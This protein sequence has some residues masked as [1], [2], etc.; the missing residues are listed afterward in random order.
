VGTQYTT[1]PIPAFRP[2]S[3]SVTFNYNYGSV[4]P[5]S[6][7][8]A[9]FSAPL[10]LPDGAVLEEVRLLVSDTEPGQDILAQVVMFGQAVAGTLTCSST[11]WYNTSS[12]IFGRDILTLTGAPIVIQSRIDKSSCSNTDI[13]SQYY[14]EVLMGTPNESL[15]GAV[16]VWHRQVSPPPVTATFNDVPTS[17]PFFR[18]IEALAASGITSGCGGGNFCP[19]DVVT[20]AQLAKFLAVALGLHWPQ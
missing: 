19:N 7:E 20:R 14:L 13:Y 16:L 12:G 11:Y 4:T 5:A 1:I 3:S 15:S 2:E 17:D 18:A 9:A 10:G 8:V 6:I